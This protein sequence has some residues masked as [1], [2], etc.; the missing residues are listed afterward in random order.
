M[1][2]A[3]A[4]SAQRRSVSATVVG[5][6]GVGGELGGGAAEEHGGRRGR[7]TSPAAARLL[8]R[9]EQALPVG[10]RLRGEDVGVAGVDGGYAGRGQRVAAGPRVAVALDDDG[11]VAGAD[12]PAVVGRVGGEQRA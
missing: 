8:E 4:W 7:A 3:R 2:R 6:V 9:L 11:D 5:E 1:P 12:R 10:G